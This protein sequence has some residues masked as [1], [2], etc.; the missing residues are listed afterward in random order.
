MTLR[1]LFL[2]LYLPAGKRTVPPPAGFAAV[3]ALLTAVV[4]LVEPS[5][6]AP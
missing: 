5:P 2:D 6:L 3:T 1:V 4:S